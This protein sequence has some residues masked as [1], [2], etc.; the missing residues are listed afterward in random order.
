M[1]DSENF[2]SILYI[3]VR[4]SSDKILGFKYE[5]FDLVGHDSNENW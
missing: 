5:N 3:N 4:N 1:S 2:V